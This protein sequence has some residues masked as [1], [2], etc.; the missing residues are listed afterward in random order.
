M[1]IQ[2][3]RSG[4]IRSYV[5]TNIRVYVS[6]HTQCRCVRAYA[7]SPTHIVTWRLHTPRFGLYHVIWHFVLCFQEVTQRHNLYHNE[8][9]YCRTI[10]Y[11]LIFLYDTAIIYTRCVVSRRIIHV[12]YVRF[13]KNVCTFIL[14]VLSLIRLIN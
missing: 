7:H 2:H 5:H 10:I 1:H 9:V 12:H 11:S 8:H 4:S 3:P 14:G 13:S 6:L